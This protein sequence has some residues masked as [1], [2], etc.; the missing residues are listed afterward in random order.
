MTKKA[1]TQN[2][3]AKNAPFRESRH[4]GKITIHIGENNVDNS[5]VSSPEKS[6]ELRKH[7]ESS[8]EALKK[9]LIKYDE[10]LGNDAD[11]KSIETQFRQDLQPYKKNVLELVKEELSSS[12]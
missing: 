1:R 5:I 7:V 9:V 6:Y 3:L 12:E 4:D 11:R 2:S 8:D 10:S